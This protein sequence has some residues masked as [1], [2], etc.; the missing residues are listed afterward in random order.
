MERQDND[1]SGWRKSSRSPS[2]ADCVEVRVRDDEVHVRNSH[3]PDGPV[4]T[5][6]RSE[7]S[8]FVEGVADGEMSG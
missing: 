2:G 8:A 3:D 6:T 5:F 7:W 1:A 4:L